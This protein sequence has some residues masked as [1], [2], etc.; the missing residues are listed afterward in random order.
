MSPSIELFAEVVPVR[1][2]FGLR[3]FFLVTKRSYFLTYF[4]HNRVCYYQFGRKTGKPFSFIGGAFVSLI[5]AG[6]L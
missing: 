2:S 1:L 5:I 6:C 4:E 3:S